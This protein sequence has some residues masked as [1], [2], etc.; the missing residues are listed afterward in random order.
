VTPASQARAGL[1][2]PEEPLVK[3]AR[4]ARQAQAGARELEVLQEWAA[5]QARVV[6]L[7]GLEAEVRLG[8]AP[9]RA[10]ARSVPPCGDGS[11]SGC[12]IPTA[13]DVSRTSAERS[14]TR[15]T[16]S[17][18]SMTSPDAP[19]I[20]DTTI[21]AS[22][23]ASERCPAAAAR[24]LTPTMAAC[25]APASRLASESCSRSSAGQYPERSTVAAMTQPHLDGGRSVRRVRG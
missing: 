17:V 2:A 9:A 25:T 20:A 12:K 15:L 16:M 21:R 6:R 4:E 11:P 1:P 24:Q 5:V 7:V 8:Q 13:T 10:P 19:T 14:M 18:R 22:A 23:P 3:R